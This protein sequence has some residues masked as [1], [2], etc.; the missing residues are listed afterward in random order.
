M[1]QATSRCEAYDTVTD[2]WFQIESLPM[3]CS[4]TTATVMNNR[5][6]YILHQSP[7][8]IQASSDNAAVN[9]AQAM[10]SATKLVICRLDTGPESQFPKDGRKRDFGYVLAQHRWTKFEVNTAAFRGSCPTAGLSIGPSEMIIFG[11]QTA[12]FFRMDT[13][14][15]ID[16]KVGMKAH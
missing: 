13:S 4:N 9:T 1:V 14:Q 2:H 7:N 5:E 10:Q 12:Q 8:Q 6:V 16:S 3:A 15:A 11:G